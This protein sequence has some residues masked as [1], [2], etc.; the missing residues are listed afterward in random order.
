M[1][2]LACFALVVALA[3]CGGKSGSSSTTP[4]NAGGSGSAA[5]KL[6]WEAA[7]TVGATFT[8]TTDMEDGGGDP[9]V[10]KVSAV[11][12]QGGD[13][14]YTLDWGEDGN[15]PSKIIVRGEL[16]LLNEAQPEDMQEPSDTPAGTCY[17]ED[18]SNP[19][20]CDDVCD[21]QL[22]LNDSGIVSVF[23]LYAPNYESYS[24]K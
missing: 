15:G 21:G 23:G 2:R 13:R 9:V 1:R 14:V 22:C 8:L 11:D 3:A 19:D 20:G 12:D 24:A 18:F 6:P 10:V 7:L 4:G 16:V 5:N 17:G